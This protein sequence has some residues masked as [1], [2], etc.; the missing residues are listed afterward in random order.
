VI[1]SRGLEPSSQ[2]Q[3]C[4]DDFV[5]AGG[6][7]AQHSAAAAKETHW[8]LTVKVL[9][10]SSHTLIGRSLIALLQSLPS[11]EPIE[12]SQCNTSTIIGTVH[13]S[14]PD[15]VLLEANTDFPSA[16][17]TARMLVAEIPS[18]HLVMLGSE[19]DDAS[20]FEAIFAGADGY[21]TADAS[22]DTLTNTLSGVIRG[23]LGL[24]RR[25]A[26]RVVRQLRQGAHSRLASTPLDADSKLTRREQEI[27]DLVR[28]GLRS[29]E[30]AEQL[31]IAETTVYKHIQKILEKLQVHSRAQA[32]LISAETDGRQPGAGRG[33]P[34]ASPGVSPR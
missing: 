13:A 25:A 22:T 30:I 10:V 26:L 28:H 6:G 23:E 17:A 21:L 32:I 27:F 12:A 29:R 24:T 34:R 2:L 11:G 15:V 8:R 1:R 7:L 16:L 31:S 33:A 4:P 9:V 5:Y 14:E 19:A 3:E 18:V 20:T